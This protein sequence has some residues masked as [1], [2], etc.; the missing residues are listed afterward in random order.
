MGIVQSNEGKI[1]DVMPKTLTEH[2]MFGPTMHK[3]GNSS[4]L[5]RNGH[6]IL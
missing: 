6:S 1:S 4:L 5:P 2:Q 3:S